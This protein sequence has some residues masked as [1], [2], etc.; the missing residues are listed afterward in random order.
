M[1]INVNSTPGLFMLFFFFI[2]FLQYVRFFKSNHQGL[3][4]VAAKDIN[5][6]WLALGT[7]EGTSKNNKHSDGHV[8]LI[9]KWEVYGTYLFD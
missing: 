3:A 6:I 1:R 7:L 8:Q 9:N 5:L 4:A 2:L